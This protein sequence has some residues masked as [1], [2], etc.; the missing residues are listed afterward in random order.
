MSFGSDSPGGAN[1][2]VGGSSFGGSGGGGLGIDYGFTGMGTT[3]GLTAGWDSSPGYTFGS[4]TDQGFNVGPGGYD[5]SGGLGSGL[6]GF[7]SVGSPADY[8]FNS[9][10]DMSQLGQS[11]YGLSPTGYPLVG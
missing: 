10:F 7:T 2:G 3:P 8:S 9:L 1:E 6:N 11:N 4:G 5:I